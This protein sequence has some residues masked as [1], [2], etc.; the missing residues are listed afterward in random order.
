MSTSEISS[1]YRKLS[2][3]VLAG[4]LVLANSPKSFAQVVIAPTTPQ[5][6]SSN[7]ASAEPLVPRPHTKPCVVNLFQNMEFADFNAKSFSYTPPSACPGPWSKVVFTADFTVTSG[8]QYDRTA[9]FSLGHVNL[10]YG[11]TAEPR[12]TLS[13]SWHV[14]NDVTDLAPLFK[15]AQTGEADLGNFVGVYNGVTYDGII[16]ANAA[17]EFYPASWKDPAPPTPSVVVPLPDAPGGAATLST[18][19]SQLSQQVTLPTNI[20][21]LYL[22]VIS[23]SQSNDE[24]W[25]LCVPNDVASELQ[26]CGNTGFRETEV[27][28]DGTPAGV[29]PVYPWI[30]TGG[31]DPYLWEPLPGI[32]TLNFKPFRVDLTPFA[33]VLS[34]GK[35]HSVSISVFNANSYFLATGTLLVYTDPSGSQF[36]GGILHNDLAAAPT[37][38]VSENLTTDSSGNISGSVSVSSA[39][40]YTITGYINTGHGKVTASVQQQMNFQNTQQFTINATS[41]IQGVT[42]STTANQK[43]TIQEGPFAYSTE[44]HFSYPLGVTY[45]YVVNSDGSAAQTTTSDQQLMAN[46]KRSLN[47][48]PLYFNN[49]KEEVSSTDTLNFDSSGNFLGPTGTAAAS[50]V[51]KDSL[52]GCYSRTL[53]AADKVLTGVEDNQQCPKYSFGW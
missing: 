44:E 34:D 26:S 16:Y 40:K 49:A 12:R 37:P 51:Q 18:T 53:T 38:T 36:S 11:T 8:R 25:Y 47:G 9:Q 32:Q 48:I 17:L 7:P 46:H 13:P 41:Y 23:Q 20:S 52:H 10:Y 2:F 50:Y 5:V 3:A 14:E 31:I 28:V 43:S 21:R 35:Q 4:A 19:A 39:R 6:G 15:S 45:S 22:D 1:L 42:Q 29:A 33:G 30:F 27:S 24:F